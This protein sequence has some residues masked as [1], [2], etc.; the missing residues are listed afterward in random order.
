M[1]APL[2]FVIL[3][4]EAPDNNVK[5]I[6]PDRLNALRSRHGHVLDVL[7]VGVL[8]KFSEGATTEIRGSEG[9]RAAEGSE[10]EGSST[11][12]NRGGRSRALVDGTY[13]TETTR[14]LGV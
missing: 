14:G 13:A 11:G 3:V 9:H 5:P 10:K 8:V 2:R 12:Q 6:I 7:T 1:V 4:M